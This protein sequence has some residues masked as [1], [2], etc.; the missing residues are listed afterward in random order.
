MGPYLSDAKDGLRNGA[1]L[2][3]IDQREERKDDAKVGLSIKQHFHQVHHTG[4]ALSVTPP[5]AM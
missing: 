2:F 4:G 1:F 5:A 3:L